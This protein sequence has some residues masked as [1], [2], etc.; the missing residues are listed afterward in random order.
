MI[1][2]E[3]KLGELEDSLALALTEIL[4]RLFHE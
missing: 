2:A 1:N 4:E 3:D